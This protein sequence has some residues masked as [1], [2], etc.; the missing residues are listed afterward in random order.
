MKLWNRNKRRK[1]MLYHHLLTSRKPLLT[2]KGQRVALEPWEAAPPHPSSASF[3]PLLLLLLLFLLLLPLHLISLQWAKISFFRFT[4]KTNAHHQ[5]LTQT[6]RYLP[7][8]EK[9]NSDTERE[10]T[11]KHPACFSG[12]AVSAKARKCLVLVEWRHRNAII[13]QNIWF[14]CTHTCPSVLLSNVF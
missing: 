10:G 1:D 2:G 13:S 14:S 11:V 4:M 6:G 7:E 8:R 5:Q 12:G 3:P 9:N